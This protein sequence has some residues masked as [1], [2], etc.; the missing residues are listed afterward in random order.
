MNWNTLDIF[1]LNTEQFT[2]NATD[3]RS[4]FPVRRGVG[5]LS[6][7]GEQHTRSNLL[8]RTAHDL[9][10]GACLSSLASYFLTEKLKCLDKW[11]QREFPPLILWGRASCPKAY[12]YMP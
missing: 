4:S 8:M 9:Q 11:N 1:V 6:E 2:M 5:I 7:S 3:N 12:V 10:E